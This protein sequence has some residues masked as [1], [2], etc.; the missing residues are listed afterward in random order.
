MATARPYK[1]EIAPYT[2]PEGLTVDQADDLAKYFF[3]RTFTVFAGL[4]GTPSLRLHYIGTMSEPQLFRGPT[5][6]EAFRRAGVD[7][8]S[9]EKVS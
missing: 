7:L 4:I 3:G 9:F 2:D 6:S 1:A 5:W 8:R